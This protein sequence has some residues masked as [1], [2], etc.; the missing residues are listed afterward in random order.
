MPCDVGA[1]GDTPHRRGVR[2]REQVGGAGRSVHLYRARARRSILARRAAFYRHALLLAVRL[3]L[4]AAEGSFRAAE[5]QLP[6][7]S[8]SVGLLQLR[9][10]ERLA[11]ADVL[12]RSSAETTVT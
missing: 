10:D 6:R 9:R 5:G 1:S 7:Q 2:G 4:A 12:L 3:A 8:F 11:H